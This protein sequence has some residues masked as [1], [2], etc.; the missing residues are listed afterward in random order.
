[1]RRILEEKATADLVL[2]RRVEHIERLRHHPNVLASS[3][4]HAIDFA[5]SSASRMHARAK[6]GQFANFV[7][8]AKTKA[9]ERRAEDDEHRAHSTERIP[10]MERGSS[11]TAFV[12]EA[13]DKARERRVDDSNNT[14]PQRTPLTE[15][16]PAALDGSPT[17]MSGRSVPPAIEQRRLRDMARS[18]AGDV[19][20][21]VA[22]RL[23]DR[24][25]RLQARVSSSHSLPATP[26]PET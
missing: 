2:T 6:N 24:G 10:G 12:R 18:S 9:R 3:L 14:T 1:M 23:D 15:E 17:P 5:G 22:K 21:G 16:G 13:R 8:E 7:R 19:L 20:K 25:S 26:T 11:F 4:N